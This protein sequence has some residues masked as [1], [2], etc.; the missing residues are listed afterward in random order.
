MFLKPSLC[1]C[2]ILLFT[3]VWTSAQAPPKAPLTCT[4]IVGDLY[5]QT[6]QLQRERNELQ[7][8]K[9]AQ[10]AALKDLIAQLQDA[11]AKCGDACKE[12]APE[13]AK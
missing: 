11:K 7:A 5:I 8:T 12:K 4:D 2:L 13:P 6:A 9:D 10:Q 1:L 3:A